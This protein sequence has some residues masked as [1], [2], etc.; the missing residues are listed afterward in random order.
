MLCMLAPILAG[1]FVSLS[2]YLML[3]TLNAQA[4]EKVILVVGFV[5]HSFAIPVR[6]VEC[7]AHFFTYLC[8]IFS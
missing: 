1:L 4:L 8:F 2:T 7:G 6:F 5:V 3:E